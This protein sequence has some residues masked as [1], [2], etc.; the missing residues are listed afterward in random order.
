MTL[1]YDRVRDFLILH[2]TATERDD[3][4]F[5]NHVRTME[6][7]GSLDEKIAAFRERGLIMKYRDGLFLHPSWISVFIGQRIVPRHWD[8]RVDAIPLD[9]AAA[10]LAQLR[11]H[12]AETVD[13]LEPHAAALARYCPAEAVAG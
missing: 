10:T 4:P 6:L 2:Y 13:G 5:W 3:S 8:P 11:R 7:P 9:Q 1:E 12:I